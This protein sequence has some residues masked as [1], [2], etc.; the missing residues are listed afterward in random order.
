MSKDKLNPKFKYVGK[1]RITP[2]GYSF[3]IESTA[4]FLNKESLKLY[5]IPP[6]QNKFC[7]KCGA[8]SGV[9]SLC[10]ECYKKTKGEKKND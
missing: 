2:K 5:I 1:A 10:F 3:Q 9:Y 8:P 6:I 7:S 4:F